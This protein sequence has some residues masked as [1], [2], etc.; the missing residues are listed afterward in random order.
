MW[1]AADRCGIVSEM[2]FI[3][4]S[5]PRNTYYRGLQSDGD[6]QPAGLPMRPEISVISTVRIYFQ[7]PAALQAK[8]MSP[9]ESG[10]TTS[11]RN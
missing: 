8:P 2:P 7:S 11:S 5:R 10:A 3:R 4:A 9:A 1:L 6:I